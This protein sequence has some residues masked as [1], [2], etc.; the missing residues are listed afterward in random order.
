M[1]RKVR[2][3]KLP[4]GYSISNG[5]LLKSAKTGGFKTGDQ[6]NFGMVLFLNL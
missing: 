4:E 5:K 3:N 6:H 1:K 2:I